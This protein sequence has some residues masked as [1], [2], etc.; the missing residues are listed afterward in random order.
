M[1]YMKKYKEFVN[2]AELATNAIDLKTRQEE[3]RKDIESDVTVKPIDKDLIAKNKAET[4]NI[5]KTK[6]TIDKNLK[7]TETKRNQVETD[8]KIHQD[9]ETND[10]T[11]ETKKK[12]QTSIETTKK[13][14]DNLDKQIK[15]TKELS[16]LKKQESDAKLKKEQQKK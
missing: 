9:L 4:D 5:N 7:D 11:P 15:L 6:E 8:M 13:D 2:E 1:N 3:I 14:V 16:D 10:Y 12:L